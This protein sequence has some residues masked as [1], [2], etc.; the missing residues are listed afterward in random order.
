MKKFPDIEE[1]LLCNDVNTLLY[2]QSDPT[3]FALVIAQGDEHQGIL[4]TREEWFEVQAR[5]N[6]LIEEH[7]ENGQTH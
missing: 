4:I 2:S 1:T 5:I 6:Q 7:M 3:V